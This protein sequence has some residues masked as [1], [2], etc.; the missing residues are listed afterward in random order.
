M[1][2]GGVEEQ[3][4]LMLASL[5]HVAFT[6]CQD[7]WICPGSLLSTYYVKFVRKL[8]VLNSNGLRKTYW[9]KVIPPKVNI[10]CW[11]LSLNH[12]P[13]NLNMFVRGVDIGDLQ[14]PSCNL[15]VEDLNHIF[16]GCD[17]ASQV[18]SYVANWVDR[19]FHKWKDRQ[20]FWN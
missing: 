4:T 17:I 7:H 5:T 2:R 16:F 1:S 15:V 10:L 13:D 19:P 12:L 3:L 18:W 9:S 6:D 8:L 14:C 20:E 11:R